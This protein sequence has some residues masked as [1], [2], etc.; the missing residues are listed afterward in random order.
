M[1]RLKTLLQG[2]YVKRQMNAML[3]SMQTLTR[4]QTQIQERRNRLSEE[5]KARHRLLQQKGHQKE[6]NQNQ[7]LVIN[8]HIFYQ[9]LLTKMLMDQIVLQVMAGD[10]DSSNK[11][12]AQIKARSVNRKEA[13]VRRER[14]L[15]YAYSHQVYIY[16]HIN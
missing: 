7:N 12:K 16:I 8:F 6:H 5:N 1:A 9:F 10:F 4:L 14:A 13:S 3:S 11:S 15:A 2:R